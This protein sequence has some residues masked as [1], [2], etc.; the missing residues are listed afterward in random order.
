LL[1]VPKTTQSPDWPRTSL[2]SSQLSTGFAKKTGNSLVNQPWPWW[3]AYPPSEKK[4]ERKNLQSHHG[5]VREGEKTW[6][7]DLA[8]L[9]TGH[10]RVTGPLKDG[11]SSVTDHSSLSIRL[12]RD[13]NFTVRD[14]LTQVGQRARVTCSG[15]VPHAR[16][17]FG[18]I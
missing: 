16:S 4:R 15:C 2:L 12:L 6:R 11:E 13:S 1:Y 7:L 3:L 18:P 14:E 10:W 8:V 5:T 9:V 17:S